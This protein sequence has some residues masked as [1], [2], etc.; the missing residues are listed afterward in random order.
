MKR[1][2]ASRFYFIDGCLVSTTVI[3]GLRHLHTL[4]YAS[5][6]AT[7]TY[8]TRIARSYL[9]PCL[10]FLRRLVKPVDI[11]GLL[12]HPSIGTYLKA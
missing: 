8:I 11:A 2:W 9:F 12:I 7:K 6:L 1:C 10:H 4:D 3:P 5:G